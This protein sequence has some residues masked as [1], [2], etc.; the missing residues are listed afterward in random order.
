MVTNAARTPREPVGP[1]RMR[2]IVLAFLLSLGAGIGLAFLL[3]YLD[4]TL[5]TVEDVDK[6]LH[7][8]SLALIPS[9]HERPRLRG[10]RRG[11]PPTEI[12]EVT[13]LALTSDVRSP[14]A[15]AYRHLRTC[16]FI[17]RRSAAEDDPV[18]SASRPRAYPYQ[19]VK[20]PIMLAQNLARNFAVYSP[21]ATTRP[22]QLRPSTRAA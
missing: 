8:P 5:K 6:Y 14:I 2:T 11:A 16:A 12:S 21:P 3:D 19:T 22:L 20:N 9:R 4:D 18:T 17:V 1:P 15:E 10:G 13:A 7:L